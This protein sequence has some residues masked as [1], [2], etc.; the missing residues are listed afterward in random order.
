MTDEIKEL[1]AAEDIEAS[2]EAPAN[3]TIIE[4]VVEAA[5]EVEAPAEP[6]VSVETPKPIEAPAKA[7]EPV[8]EE[9]GSQVD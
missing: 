2:S 5:A 6:I 7:T 8:K 9:I 3:E 4:P 1:D